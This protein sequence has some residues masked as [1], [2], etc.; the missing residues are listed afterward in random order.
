M[1]N[2]IINRYRPKKTTI[3]TSKEIKPKLIEKKILRKLLAKS[4]K[5]KNLIKKY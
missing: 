1:I 4:Y 2:T 5:K 3:N